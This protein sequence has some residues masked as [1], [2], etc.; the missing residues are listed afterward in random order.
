MGGSRGIG[1]AIALT[2]AREGAR[3]VVNY[4]KGA[5]RARICFKSYGLNLC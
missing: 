1:K 5:K 3:V 2:L 4:V